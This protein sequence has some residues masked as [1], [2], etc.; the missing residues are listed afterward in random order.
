MVDLYLKEAPHLVKAVNASLLLDCAILEPHLVCFDSSYLFWE[1]GRLL[2]F[3]ILSRLDTC[4][5]YL[6][7]LLLFFLAHNFN[8]ILDHDTRFLVL[9]SD[10]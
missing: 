9:R 4:S 10:E 6:N 1:L 7:L 3:R 5:F 8:D 2:F